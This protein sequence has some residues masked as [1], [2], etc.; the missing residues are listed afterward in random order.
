M[1]TTKHFLPPEEFNAIYGRVPRLT[2][3][4]IVRTDKGIILTKRS[5]EPCIGQWHIPGGTVRFAEPLHDAVKRIA[6]DELGVTVEIDTLLGYIEYP[7]MLADGYKGWPVGITFETHITE[8]ELRG[9]D[10]GEEVGQFTTVPPN[11]ITEQAAFLNMHI[12]GVR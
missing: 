5:M 3:E 11:T 6:Q 7:R 10:Q 8:G 2:V 12:F 9:S 1:N 4:I